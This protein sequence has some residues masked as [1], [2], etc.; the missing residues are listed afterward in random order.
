LGYHHRLAAQ[1]TL[2]FMVNEFK[3]QTIWR[4]LLD[5]TI[6][7]GIVDG[8]VIVQMVASSKRDYSK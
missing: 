5:W 8:M 4:T 6:A 3:L 7:I 2:L 1:T